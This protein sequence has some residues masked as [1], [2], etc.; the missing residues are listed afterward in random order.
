[1][2]KLFLSISMLALSAWSASA[3]VTQLTHDIDVA[4]QE[5]WVD[6]VFNAMT[7]EQKVGQLIAQAVAPKD[8]P[9]AKAEIKRLITRYHIG[10]LY[11]STGDLKNHAELINYARTFPG[12]QVMVG[13]DGEWGLSMRIPKTPRFPK[14]MMLGAISDNELLYNYGLEMARECEL[15]GINVNFAPAIDVNSNAKNPVIGTRSYGEDPINVSQKAIAYSRGLEDGGVLSVAKH[16]PGHGDTTEDS[17]K[18]LPM[19]SR[20][21]EDIEAI[22]LLPFENYIKAGLSGVMVAHLNIPA[23]N[24][25]TKPSSLCENVVTGLLKSKLG[26]EGLVFTDALTMKGARVAEKSNGLLALKAGADVLLEPQGLEKSFRDMVAEYKAGKEAKRLVDASCKKI[27]K[28]KYA[29]GLTEGK[30]VDVATLM[31][32]INNSDAELTLRELYSGAITALKNEAGMLPLKRLDKKVVAVAL[33][34]NTKTEFTETC[35]LYTNVDVMFANSNGIVN[36]AKIDNESRVIVGIYD[37]KLATQNNLKSIIKRVGGRNVVPVFFVKPYDLAPFADEIELCS[38]AILAY[39]E[40]E[41]AQ[42]YAAQAVFG[43]IDVTGRI[44]VSVEGV[45]S[46]GDG[47]DIQ[48]SRLGYGMPEEVGLDSIFLAKTDSLIVLGLKEG[49]FTGG[50]L[51]IARKNK[52]VYNRSFGYTDDKKTTK[53]DDNSLFDL[54]SVSKAT[55]TLPGVM[56]AIDSGLMSLDAKLCEYIPELKETGKTEMTITDVLYHETGMAPYIDVYHLFTDSTTYEGELV[57]G[58]R[59]ATHNKAAGGGF[60]NGNAKVRKDIASEV[61][62]KKFDRQIGKNLYVG[63]VTYDTIMNI[64]YNL[65][66]RDDRNYKYSC[67][68]FCML[69]KAEENV[70]G[71]PHDQYVYDNIYHRLGAYR[72]VY[73]PLKYFNKNEIVAT[74][75]DEFFRG[76]MVQGVVHDE[77]AAFSGGVQGNAGFFSNANDLA[78]LCGMWLNGGDYGNEQLLSSDIVTEFLT[79]KSPNSHRGLGF[80][81]PRVDDPDNSSTC[82]EADASVVGHTGFTGTCFWVDPKNDMIYIFLS[83]RVCPTRKN[84]AFG[85]V[86]ARA[87][88]FGE[89]YKSLDRT[90]NLVK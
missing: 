74:E 10:C 80:D 70:T 42:N 6:S 76:G 65:P 34:E 5:A 54:A 29:L 84:P 63:Q 67:L 52:I 27:L 81:K 2:K 61:R 77:T 38:A 13:V 23:M 46:C 36:V 86:G 16:F 40:H 79:A 71:V 78:K 18:T 24:T 73:T 11:F 85:R 57:E 20:P 69:M 4:Q 1:M 75:V 33:G 87:N 19:V 32:R 21:M 58:K 39:E 62:T 59:S 3:Q 8:I 50:Q 22:D 7:P 48:S 49:A 47:V 66:L 37:K 53:V 31:E 35:K 9:A 45:A 56:K 60:L 30:Q 82:A 68:N 44:P 51:L 17:H 55:G 90:G 14:N 43:G 83:N 72:S 88:I 26:F 12:V 89:V 15:M 64:I 28:Y 25:G 41:F